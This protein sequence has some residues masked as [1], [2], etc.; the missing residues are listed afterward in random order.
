MRVA[1][2][3]HVEWVEFVRVP[4]VPQPGEIVHAFETWEEPAGGG[5]VAAVQLA[6]LAG[7][8]HVLHGA[9]SR[10]ARAALPG[11]ADPARRRGEGDSR[12]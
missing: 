9:R 12:R 8:V 6:Q 5:A 11:G 3:G 7:V 2:V 1:V 4:A 10:R